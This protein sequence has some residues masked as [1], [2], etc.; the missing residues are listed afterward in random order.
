M[1]PEMSGFEI[2]EHLK[3]IEKL[4][5]VPVIFL[6]SLTE[7]DDKIQAFKAGGV[8]YIT[9]P[10]QKEE[11]LARIRAHLQIRFLQKQL[12]ERI[13]ILREREIELS[14]L[15]QKKDDLVRTVSH[16]IKN[17]LTGIIGLVKLM[18]DSDKVTEEEQK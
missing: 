11:T 10:F 7:T 8:D 1:M 5:D 14:R 4:N 17:P 18:K 15:N 16:D 6:S 3:N 9:K 13:K 2:I 12:N